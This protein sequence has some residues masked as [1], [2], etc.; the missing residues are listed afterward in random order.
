M[1]LYLL[2]LNRYN[3]IIKVLIYIIL[4]AR[5]MFSRQKAPLFTAAVRREK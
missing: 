1:S 3:Y 4:I 5:K 2:R